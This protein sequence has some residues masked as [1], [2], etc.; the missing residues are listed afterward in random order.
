MMKLRCNKRRA[1]VTA[2]ALVGLTATSNS[3]VFDFVNA[4]TKQN[5]AGTGARAVPKAK[6]MDFGDG[7]ENYPSVDDGTDD[8]GEG[9]LERR[10][11]TSDPRTFGPAGQG[12]DDWDDPSYEQ[13]SPRPYHTRKNQAADERRSRR[14]SDGY[15]EAY[16]DTLFT[17]G[18]YDPSDY[19]IQADSDP[20]GAGAGSAN[21]VPANY[22]WNVKQAAAQA[23]AAQAGAGSSSDAPEATNEA[24]EHQQ[25]MLT[26]LAEALGMTVSETK[27]LP[28]R[29]P[30]QPRIP[31][32]KYFDRMEDTYRTNM[33]LFGRATALPLEHMPEH[34]K[35]TMEQTGAGEVPRSV[36]RR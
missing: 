6:A 3:G 29:D 1:G 21:G 15:E 17:R 23:Q 9:L 32:V 33:A 5:G 12:T 30:L 25:G 8:V 35:R 27:P 4:V 14:A 16:E 18:Y 28:P 19:E 34:I 13:L 26:K 11:A 22:P 10:Q 2:T 31:G 7:L 24:Q 36:L 20:R